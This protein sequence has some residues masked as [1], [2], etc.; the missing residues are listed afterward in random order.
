M[1]NILNGTQFAPYS[2]H[3]N[4]KRPLPVV[5][6]DQF[7]RKLHG[8][9]TVVKD[10]F[11]GPLNK[12]SVHWSSYQR[13]KASGS[14][15]PMR[16]VVSALGAYYYELA[17]YMSYFL[18][19]LDGSSI[20]CSAQMVKDELT[21]RASEGFLVSYDIAS[22]FTNVPL[23]DAVAIAADLLP[24]SSCLSKNVFKELLLLC[25]H[26]TLLT[27]EDKTYLQCDGVAMGSPVGP[28]LANIYVNHLEK[29]LRNAPVRIKY[30]RRYVDDTLVMVDSHDDAKKVLDWLNSLSTLVFT[31]ELSD[32][33]GDI[34]FLDLNIKRSGDTYITGVHVK[35]TNTSLLCN[36]TSMSPKC[37]KVSIIRSLLWR[38]HVNTSTWSLFNDEIQRIQELSKRNAFPSSLVDAIIKDFVSSMV[39]NSRPLVESGTEEKLL[40]LQYRGQPTMA[41][42][43]KLR[44]IVSNVRIVYTTMK[45]KQLFASSRNIKLKEKF[46]VVYQYQC[47]KCNKLYVGRTKRIMYHRIEEHKRNELFDHHFGCGASKSFNDCFSILA[48]AQNFKDL[49]ILE[50]L[51]IKI[52]KPCLNTQLAGDGNTHILSLTNF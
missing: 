17:S 19:Q 51:Y 33:S 27:F 41:L 39:N 40:L 38:A 13:I 12:S 14:K 25:S 3:G 18:K 48:Q 22:L 43:K 45:A 7:N 24:D 6:E 28:L 49:C 2:L 46:K 5:V 30:Y 4:V 21:K 50:A 29:Q 16:P 37:Y 52:L 26:N 31:M 35:E 10:D 23:K 20:D 36:Y 34:H 15:V 47:P 9:L 42:A 1:M 11:I 32:S 8:L 44:S